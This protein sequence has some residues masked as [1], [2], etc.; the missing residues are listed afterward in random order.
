MS[1]NSHAP[2]SDEPAPTLDRLPATPHELPYDRAKIDDLL[3]RVREGATVDLLGELLAAVDWSVF[4]GAD[5]QPL[6]PLERAELHTYYRAK[7]ADIGPLFLAE[8]L[9]TEFM[10]EQRARGD[11]VF[12]DRLLALGRGE[13]ELWAEIR[14]FFR[15]KEMA[16][17]MLVAAH[18][19]DQA[20]SAEVGPDALGANDR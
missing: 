1:V 7:F 4:R 17:A 8:L 14:R 12:S 19:P 3:T 11:I 9:S 16:T 5:G 10:T 2:L 6:A 20:D 18:R 13:P 15:R